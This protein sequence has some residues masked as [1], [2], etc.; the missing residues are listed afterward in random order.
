MVEYP[1]MYKPVLKV[2]HGLYD[3]VLNI[4]KD[5][6]KK[7]IFLTLPTI[8][9]ATRKGRVEEVKQARAN[10]NRE[11]GAILQAAVK[12]MESDIKEDDDLRTD[13]NV[14]FFMNEVKAFIKQY[15]ARDVL[16][17]LEKVEKKQTVLLMK[18]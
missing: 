1:D 16:P 11:I 2:F 7:K 13:K 12:N 9:Q 6:S 8:T 4:Q 15:K 14:P 10:A 3:G 5:D 17:A 18:E